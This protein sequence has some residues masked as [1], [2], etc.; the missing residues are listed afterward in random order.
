[1]LETTKI[2]PEFDKLKGISP[3]W[4]NEKS[5]IDILK[6]DY[7]A[8]KQFIMNEKPINDKI[9][10][11]CYILVL[12]KEENERL[13]IRKRHN[14]KEHREIIYKDRMQ[15]SKF[16][17]LWENDK[18][19]TI[20]K[21][22]FS[23]ELNSPINNQYRHSFSIQDSE[24]IGEIQRLIWSKYKYQSSTNENYKNNLN[25]QREIN[26][27]ETRKKELAKSVKKYLSTNTSLGKNQIIYIVGIL[28]QISGLEKNL[29]QE[30][31][32]ETILM[33]IP[34]YNSFN[35]FVIKKVRTKY[36]K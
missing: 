13:E 32:N 24:L 9:D 12:L 17:K 10:N 36:F 6:S 18:S 22:N 27:P 5:C 28:F 21:L 25:Y 15:V 30:K 31:Y 33:E 7:E 1:M 3:F 16:L 4:D 2:H 8:V 23:Y 20:D 26:K 29:T 34:P 19:I 35:E 11:I 14:Y